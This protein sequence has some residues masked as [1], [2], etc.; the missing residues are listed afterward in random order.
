MRNGNHQLLSLPALADALKLPKEWIKA[1]A[2]A[3][4]IPHLKVGDKYRFNRKKVV[5][6]LADR[7]ARAAKEVDHE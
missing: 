2:D 4:R 5:A 6:L 3:G 7:A 1:E